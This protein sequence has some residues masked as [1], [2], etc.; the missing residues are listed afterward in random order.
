MDSRPTQTFDGTSRRSRARSCETRTD[1]KG[2][3]SIFFSEARFAL[4]RDA[5]YR[6]VEQSLRLHSPIV[7]RAGRLLGDAK[8]HRGV[9][10]GGRAAVRSFSQCP[11]ARSVHAASFSRK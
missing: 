6:A 7:P 8:R 3:A 5:V 2:S 1:E 9:E 4:R 11:G 10:Q